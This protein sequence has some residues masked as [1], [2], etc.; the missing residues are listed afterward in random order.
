MTLRWSERA[1][2]ELA[3]QL[4]YIALDKPSAATRIADRV[5][6]T[7]LLLERWPHLGVSIGTSRRLVIPRTPFVMIYQLRGFEVLIT[8]LYHGAQRR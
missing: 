5:Q 8:R 6:Q 1:S 2:S 7:A 3:A 4:D